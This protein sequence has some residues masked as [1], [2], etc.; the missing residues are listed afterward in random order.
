MAKRPSKADAEAK[1]KKVRKRKPD[2]QMP[3]DDA[4]SIDGK[5]TEEMF[6]A[7]RAAIGCKSNEEAALAIG[8]TAAYGKILGAR[9]SVK[10]RVRAI[11]SWQADMA[12]MNGASVLMETWNLGRSDIAE[13]VIRKGNRIYLR[14]D[15]DVLT[16]TNKAIRKITCKTEEKVQRQTKA[17]QEMG[18]EPPVLLKHEITVEMHDKV[19]PLNLLAKHLGID[20][21]AAGSGDS[22]KKTW[23]DFM[24]MCINDGFADG[25]E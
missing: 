13:V 21:P 8:F 4:R 9:P 25:A 17:E 3:K 11:R 10:E 24:Q 18:E 16:H 15:K 22:K 2:G 12:K 1:P 20:K 7:A 14:D 19:G 23:L 6:A 5:L